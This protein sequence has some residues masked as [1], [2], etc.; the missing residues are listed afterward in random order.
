MKRLLMI[1]I[2]LGVLMVL[3]QESRAQKD[4]SCKDWLGLNQ[5]IK[6]FYL[7]AFRDGAA[8]SSAEMAY[9]ENRDLIKAGWPDDLEVGLVLAMVDEFCKTPDN[10]NKWLLEAMVYI[11]NRTNTP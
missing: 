5:P 2:F 9:R 6:T 3:V 11:V 8:V 4:L 1:T 10:Q 7:T